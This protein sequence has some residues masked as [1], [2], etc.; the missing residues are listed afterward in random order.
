MKKHKKRDRSSSSDD[1][2]SK[3]EL[4]RR[5][6]KLERSQERRRSRSPTYS[7]KRHRRSESSVRSRSRRLE[8]GDRR[9]LT[10]SP[11]QTRKVDSSPSRHRQRSWVER[12]ELSSCSCDRSRFSSRSVETVESTGTHS[13]R[14]RRSFS[15]ERYSYV[16]TNA[17]A[18]NNEGFNLHVENLVRPNSPD[19]ITAEGGHSPSLIINNDVELGDDF[20]A[21]LG[22]DPKEC[23]K[24]T[25]QLHKAI[26]SRWDH[27]LSNGLSDEDKRV[28]NDRHKIPENLPLLV[29]PEVNAEILAIMSAL[30]K[31]RDSG[32]SAIQ[33]QISHALSALGQGLK[34]ILEEG[35]NFPKELKENL[36][37]PLWDSGK[38]LTNLFFSL[39]QTRRTLISQ[40]VNRQVKDI[41]EKSVPDTSLFG[42]DFGEKIKSARM[43]EK[44]MAKEEEGG[45]QFRKTDIAQVVQ[46]GGRNL[47]R[48][49]IPRDTRSSIPGKTSNSAHNT[50]W[51]RTLPWLQ[52]NYLEC[53]T[54]EKLPRKYITNR[55]SIIISWNA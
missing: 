5:I 53:I 21:I 24:S 9:R 20:L 54:A 31:K 48:A 4:L 32:Y 10:R 7:S 35:N 34:I 41:I 37:T 45:D 44:T 27:I 8:S 55:T 1:E 26:S 51:R 33:N 6:H 40:T 2:L 23:G 3:K 42:L 47:T 11:T 39:S 36:M 29:P 28:L 14:R 43:L 12:G 46:G 22:S 49:N 15:A 30:H 52:Q 25:F 19:N 50:R 13:A 38:I 16:S 17:D 18:T